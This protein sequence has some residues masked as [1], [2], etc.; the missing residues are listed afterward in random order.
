MTLRRSKTDQ[1][2]RGREIGI[3]FA[4]GRF[5]PVKALE[6]WLQ[7]AGIEGG[8][9]FR[10]V[11]R[12]GRIDVG[13]LSP[14][15]VASVVKAGVQEIGLDPTCYSGHSLRAGLATSAAMAGVSTLDIRKQT[16]HASDAML[17]RYVRSGELFTNNAA[18]HLL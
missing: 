15:A 8:P 3:P 18:G 5:C 13:R 6:A 11:D 10:P 4:R 12:Y 2:G 17:A 1:A 14:D 16:G 7:L 9:V